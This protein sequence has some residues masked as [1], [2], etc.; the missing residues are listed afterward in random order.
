M[1]FCSY[2]E[3][4]IGLFGAY[5]NKS[6]LQ[7]LKSLGIEVI[8]DLTLRC[9][10]ALDEQY[11]WDGK[12]VKFPIKDYSVPK[13]WAYFAA[14]IVYIERVIRSGQKIYIHCRGGHGRS[15]V[16]VACVLRKLHG[17]DSETAIKK[18]TEFHDN[19]TEM[20]DKWRALGSPQ[21]RNQRLFVERFF[22]SFYFSK[23]YRTG[24]KAGFSPFSKHII[25]LDFG[26]FNTLEAAFLAAKAPQNV[27]YVQKIQNQIL[28]QKCLEI[29]EQQPIESDDWF[30]NYQNVF[31]KLLKVKYDQHRELIQPLLQTGLR[32][33][34][35]STHY[36]FNGNMTGISL[37][38]LREEFLNKFIDRG[39][40]E[41]EDLH[42]FDST[43]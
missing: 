24:T 40:L 41:I 29:A 17:Y 10:I 12:Y 20:R 39:L 26:T 36:A 37:M 43:L 35:D 23:A 18:T 6:Q 16:V 2:F 4:D 34:T 25:S 19:R 1:D 27:A 7:I 42:Y 5:P 14:L 9:E 32:T 13:N 31:Y 38:T 11:Q 28:T 22:S 15:G 21:T 3:S 8:I 30:H 33:I